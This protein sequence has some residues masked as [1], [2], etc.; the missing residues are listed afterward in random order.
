MVMNAPKDGKG[1][2]FIRNRNELIAR[3]HMD[4]LGRTKGK[5]KEFDRT[6]NNGERL[7]KRNQSSLFD[8]DFKKE[9][10]DFMPYSIVFETVIA[11]EKEKKLMREL[12]NKK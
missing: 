10:K 9:E 12:M 7:H 6:M 5:D 8:L 3:S 4:K 11:L 1:K 2:T